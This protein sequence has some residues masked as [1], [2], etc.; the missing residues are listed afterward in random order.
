MPDEEVVAVTP[1]EL[2][3]PSCGV[4]FSCVT[5]QAHTNI[6][7]RVVSPSV[8]PLTRC[9]SDGYLT[10]AH[11]HH[12]ITP[13]LSPLT[14]IPPRSLTPEIFVS[15]CQDQKAPMSLPHHAPYQLTP[16]VNQ[17]V[18]K[19][20][21]SSDEVDPRD[22]ASTDPSSVLR[23]ASS[24]ADLQLHLS[25]SRSEGVMP[26]PHSNPVSP[27]AAF[28]KNG[29]FGAP[30]SALAKGVQSLAPGAGKIARGMQNIGANV[31][32][33]KLKAERQEKLM[34]DPMWQAKKLACKTVIMEF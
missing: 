9:L 23:G 12:Y 2:H 1:C 20:S 29:V 33:W 7:S 5:T 22:A 16:L 28:Q 26:L 30:F 34:Q 27:L 21:H 24:A 14:P 18:R 13:P 31:D 19:L 8:S 3:L 32:P 15:G 4:L 11:H 6:P 10:S 17:R 25:A